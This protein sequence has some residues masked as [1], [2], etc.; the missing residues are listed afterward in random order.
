[1]CR[2]LLKAAARAA[3]MSACW[4]WPTGLPTMSLMSWNLQ[5][6]DLRNPACLMCGTSSY[7]HFM[8]FVSPPKES[9]VDILM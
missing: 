4:R 9:F 2:P 1:M 7:F 6:R 8:G 3:V 5:V